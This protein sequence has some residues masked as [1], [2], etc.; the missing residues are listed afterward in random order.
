MVLAK[1]VMRGLLASQIKR[2]LIIASGLSV[3]TV[4]SWKYLVQKPRIQAYA[5]FYK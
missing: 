3:I 5:D 2:N 1:P 4:M